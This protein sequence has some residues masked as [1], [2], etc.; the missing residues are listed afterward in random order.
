MTTADHQPGALKQERDVQR[1]FGRIVRRYDL[2]NRIMTGGMDL[3]WRRKAVAYAR[4][5][6][7]DRALDVAT[8]TGDLALALADAGF[9]HVI[10]LDFVVEM[11]AA[12]ESKRQ[13]RP[14]VAFVAGDAL[15]LPFPDD[16]FDVCTVSF[17]LRNMRDYGAAIREMGRVLKPGGRLI[18]LELTPY[19]KP[20]LGRLFNIYFAHVVPVLGG[21]LSGD[22]DAYRYL[23]ASVAAFPAADALA[24]LMRDNGFARVTIA[25]VGG[26]TVAFHIAVKA[27]A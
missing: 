27:S 17:G 2:M 26:G 11:I 8:G 1:M 4:E 12:A 10:G 18:C 15:R 3:R 25:R 5:G 21:L 16:T 19:R 20:V 24:G 14:N 23:P 9:A 7:H 6:G 22:R 13:G